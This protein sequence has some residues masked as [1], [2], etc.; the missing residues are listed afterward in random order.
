MICW[1][2]EFLGIFYLLCNIDTDTY[3]EREGEN[4]YTGDDWAKLID[5]VRLKL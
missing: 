4:G 1:L 5:F 2:Q 3:D